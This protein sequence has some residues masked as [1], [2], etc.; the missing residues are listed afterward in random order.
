MNLVQYQWAIL[1]IPT[2]RS[3]HSAV[4]S[5]QY[6]PPL[7]IFSPQIPHRNLIW[8]GGTVLGGGPG[9]GSG[10]S[11]VDSADQGGEGS[12]GSGPGEN[13][14]IPFTIA[15]ACAVSGIIE[16]KMIKGIKLYAKVVI[17]L[18]NYFDMEAS[19]LK[20]FLDQ[21]ENRVHHRWELPGNY[22]VFTVVMAIYHY[23][24]RIWRI[25]VTPNFLYSIYND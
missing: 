9:S 7:S 5:G 4:R 11:A 15:P 2:S 23:V 13:I 12:G 20:I 24:E 10:S 22:P 1:T 8:R 19:S 25:L 18:E 17:R 6:Y 3:T 21:V 16:N 14:V